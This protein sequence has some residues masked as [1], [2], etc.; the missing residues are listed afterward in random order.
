MTSIVPGE[1]LRKSYS[2]FF[3]VIAP[4]TFMGYCPLQIKFCNQDISNSITA[5]SFKISQQIE[6]NE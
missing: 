6:D 4:C 1:N 5:R 3:R 2:I